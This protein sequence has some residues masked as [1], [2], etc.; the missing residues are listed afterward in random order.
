MANMA[1]KKIKL[2]IVDFPLQDCTHLQ[3]GSTYFSFICSTMQIS[4]LSLNVNEIQ[5]F[6]YHGYVM[7]YL[8]SDLTDIRWY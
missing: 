8:N 7:S 1:K 5:I 3:T 4:I 6:C 2:T